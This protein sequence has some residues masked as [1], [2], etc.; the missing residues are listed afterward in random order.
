MSPRPPQVRSFVAL[1][2]SEGATVHCGEGVDR[3]ELPEG[4]AG[5]YFLPATVL[6]GVADRSRVMQEE[7][8]G[9]VV[10]VSPFDSEE[11][12][13]A[14]GNGVCYGLGATVWS[15]D[16]GTVHRV[17]RRIQAGMVWT[18]CWMVRD[19]NLPFGGMKCSGTGREG[20]RDS[21]DFFTEVKT[22]SIKH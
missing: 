13:V 7:I 2:R 12:A 5:G 9:P 3:L 22:I 18:N 8:F 17:A 20:G 21:Y 14:R 6:T 19:L 4:H 11:E 10:C 1:A 16:V 15:R